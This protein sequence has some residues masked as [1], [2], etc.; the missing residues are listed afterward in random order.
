MHFKFTCNQY[1]D[2]HFIYLF[3]PL[4]P[5]LL[6][7]VLNGSVIVNELEMM[8]KFSWNILLHKGS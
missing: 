2:I 8:C 1:A 3:W 4:L 5:V 7:I 6:C